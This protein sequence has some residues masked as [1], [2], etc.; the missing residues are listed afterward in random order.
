M[1][2]D[3]VGEMIVVNVLMMVNGVIF[4]EGGVNIVLLFLWDVVVYGCFVIELC[5]MKGML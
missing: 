1:V 4:F 2:F 5:G 3:C